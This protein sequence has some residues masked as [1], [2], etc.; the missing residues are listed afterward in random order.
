[1]HEPPHPIGSY[2]VNRWPHTK[3][4]L[5]TI[6]K[7]RK[8]IN[9]FWKKKSFMYCLQFLSASW[10]E[11]TNLFENSVWVKKI[12]SSL[13][14]KNILLDHSLLFKW[15]LCSDRVNFGLVRCSFILKCIILWI[16]F[17]CFD[18]FAN[19]LVSIFCPKLDDLHQKQLVKYS[20]PY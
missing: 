20:W 12:V 8:Y 10:Y 4:S 16:D 9:S 3:K 18:Q 13:F 1:M 5:T 14:I 19:V 15:D 11:W 17:G 2:V 6:S 7:K